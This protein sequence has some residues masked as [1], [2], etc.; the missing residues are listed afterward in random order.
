V[1]ADKPFREG[2]LARGVPPERVDMLSGPFAVS[3]RGAFAAV[4]PTLE[5]LL[6]RK[7]TS[8]RD[9]VMQR[10]GSP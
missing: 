4:D 5:R 1:V 9:V 7:P 8:M 3:R 10:F 6:G 2:L